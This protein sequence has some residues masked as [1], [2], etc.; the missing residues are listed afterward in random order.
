MLDFSTTDWQMAAVT[1]L[2]VIVTA[3]IGWL[4]AVRLDD[5]D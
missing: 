5:E 1:A 3:V 2:V 4:V